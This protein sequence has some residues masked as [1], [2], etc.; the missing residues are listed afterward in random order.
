MA[1]KEAE[2]DV[3]K[4]IFGRELKKVKYKG[5]P[6]NRVLQQYLRGELK[7]E[8]RFSEQILER[9]ITGELKE[10]ML[11]EVAAHVMTCGRCSKR[12]VWLRRR[13]ELTATTKGLMQAIRRRI[14][15]TPKPIL[16]FVKRMIESPRFSDRKAFYIHLGG[17]VTVGVALGLLLFISVTPDYTLAALGD[18]SVHLLRILKG[19]AIVWG[20]WGITGLAL[21]GYKAL[22]KKR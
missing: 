9:L 11:P 7:D 20:G 16:I 8:H 6:S 15:S 1:E 18:E 17:Y 22:R 13:E 19:I 2:V 4:E 14:Y 12:I 10:W 5:H 21:H 3:F